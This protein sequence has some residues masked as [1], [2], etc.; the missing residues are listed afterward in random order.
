MAAEGDVTGSGVPSIHSV[1]PIVIAAGTSTQVAITGAVL[2]TAAPAASSDVRL[3]A[4][5]GTQIGIAP[6]SITADAMTVTINAPAGTYALQAV[7]D[8]EASNAIAVTVVPD[9]VIA[10]IMCSKCLGTMTI[11]G[12][13]FAEKPAGTDEAIGVT[14]AG[15]PLNVINWSDTEIT[16]S[17]ARCRG[18]VV[19]N[20][21]YGSSQ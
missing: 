14:E 19:V 12:A 15:R 5:D 4:A 2:T 10:D 7:K 3:T 16:L 9:V 20:G 8:G 18:N 11:T 13:N 17:G 6:D 1:D 21:V